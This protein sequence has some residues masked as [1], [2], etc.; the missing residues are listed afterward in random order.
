MPITSAE[1]QKVVDAGVAKA[2]ALG[3]RITIAVVDAAGE[4][5]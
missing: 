3:H 5:A 1:A 2:Q 4:V